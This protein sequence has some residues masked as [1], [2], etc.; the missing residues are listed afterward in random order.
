MSK[1]VKIITGWLLPF[2]FISIFDLQ[3][4]M[5]LFNESSFFGYF[6]E[7]FG[8]VV[9]AFVG[10]ISAATLFRFT[11]SNLKK[12]G[13][14]LLFILNVLMGTMLISLQVK[15]HIIM[16]I[17]ISLLIAG[18]SIFIAYKVSKDKREIAIK[19]SIVGVLVSLLPIFIVN[20]LKFFWGRLRFRSMVKPLVEFTPWYILKPFASGNE[21]MS[22][23][24]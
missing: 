13:L 9:M 3:I 7:V 2:L 15:M 14:S 11:K 1:H 17:L 22:F 10:G 21:F 23:P 20:L 8:E 6:F 18:I 19:V 12:L 5:M 4:S 24:S 16:S